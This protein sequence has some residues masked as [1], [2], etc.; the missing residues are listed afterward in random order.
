VEL[1]NWNGEIVPEVPG[2]DA[3]GIMKSTR[4]GNEKYMLHSN[5]LAEY[6][7]ASARVRLVGHG[8]S[9][10]RS[11]TDCSVQSIG[12]SQLDQEI[13]SWFGIGGR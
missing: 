12:W 3:F 8:S 1:L 2:F 4:R 11:T 13:V 6:K 5:S 7:R 10:T 9:F